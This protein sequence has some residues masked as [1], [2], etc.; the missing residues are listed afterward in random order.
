VVQ[1]S[2]NSSFYTQ[3]SQVPFTPKKFGGS[4]TERLVAIGSVC[5][6]LIAPIVVRVLMADSTPGV[7]CYKR[8]EWRLFAD[9]RQPADD[10]QR[11]GNSSSLISV[12]E[13][14]VS[15]RDN[16]LCRGF[17]ERF[18]ERPRGASLLSCSCRLCTWL[19]KVSLSSLS[20]ARSSL[21]LLLD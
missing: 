15:S 2:F 18:S 21:I 8:S 19:L 13:I 9:N 10:R 7:T 5:I 20:S 6:V 17:V 12:P 1:R 16:V 3:A 4:R 14:R 11:T